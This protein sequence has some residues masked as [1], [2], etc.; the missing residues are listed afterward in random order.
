M[1]RAATVLSRF[2]AHFEAARPGKL[3]GAVVEALAR[4]LDVQASQMAG[5]RR[6]HRVREADT[7]RD[8]MRI[9]G[10]HGI[11][12]GEVEVLSMRTTRT[13]ER[14]AA[15]AEAAPDDRETTLGALLDLWALDLPENPHAPFTPAPDPDAPPPTEEEAAEAALAVLLAAAR[16]ATGYEARR[17]ALSTRI[18]RIAA[19]HAG[20]NGT[21]RAMLEGAATAL[22]LDILS[23]QHSEDRYLHAAETR[24]RMA[25]RPDG[26]APPPDKIEIVGLEENPLRRAEQPPAERRHGECFEILRK[27]FDPARLEIS[28][29]AEG[30]RT[31]GPMIVNRDQGRGVGYAD[32]VPPGQTLTFSETGRAT[33]AGADVTAF[34]YGFEGAVFADADVPAA[35]DAVFD[36]AP[37]VTAFPS[38]ALDRGFTFPHSGSSLTVPEVAIGRT[39]MAFFVQEAHYGAAP[40]PA[41]G[42]DAIVLPAPVPTTPRPAIGF[43]SGPGAPLG[44]VFAPGPDEDR[45]SAALVSFAW[46]EHEAYKVRVLIPPRFRA[47]T[48]DPEGIDVTRRVT[49]ALDRFRPVGVAVETMFIDDRWVLGQGTLADEG[50]DAQAL[51]ALSGGT[52]LWPAPEDPGPPNG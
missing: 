27:G 38:G 22:D 50:S 30:D 23:V 4:D 36:D 51:F 49:A 47:L 32:T 41:L 3:L 15:L 11:R 18:V 26:L 25:L 31:I 45:Q 40:K 44:S 19:N 16:A 10:L 8:L 52:V 13:A 35:T 33:I 14:I 12:D 46:R 5:I 20:G 7:T 9:A 39:R 48:N 6:A 21:V 17:Q 42:A 1:G 34:A 43:F 29:I 2:P 28:V 24:D 37:F